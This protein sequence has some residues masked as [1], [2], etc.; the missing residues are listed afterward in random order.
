MIKHRNYVFLV[1]WGVIFGEYVFNKIIDICINYKLKIWEK[2]LYFF[3][4]FS[5]ID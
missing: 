5:M 1:F 3:G 4:K 2:N